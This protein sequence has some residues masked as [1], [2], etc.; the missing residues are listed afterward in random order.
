M[1]TAAKTIVAV[2]MFVPDQASALKFLLRDIAAQL[3]PAA[4]NDAALLEH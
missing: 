2:G 1:D 3:V 4:Q